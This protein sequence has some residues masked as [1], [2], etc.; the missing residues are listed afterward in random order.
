[1][2]GQDMLNSSRVFANKFKFSIR[3]NF[4]E[5]RGHSL[6]NHEFT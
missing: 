2:E 6:H 4:N 3:E 5:K 1:M